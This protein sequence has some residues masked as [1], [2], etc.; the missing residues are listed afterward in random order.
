MKLS[1]V[2]GLVLTFLVVVAAATFASC[3]TEE[4]PNVPSG[5][6]SENCDGGVLPDGSQLV[7][8]LPDFELTILSGGGCLRHYTWDGATRSVYLERRRK[9]WGRKTGLYWPG[10]G[11]HWR[12][13]GKVSRGVLNESFVEFE[14]VE[15]ALN[16]LRAGGS[17]DPSYGPFLPNVPVRPQGTSYVYRDDGLAV[18]IALRPSRR[19]LNVNVWQILIDGEKPSSLPGSTNDAITLAAPGEPIRGG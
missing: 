15:T 1:S 19:Q 6:P 10:P 5:T 9:P 8:R 17:D 7:V 14:S 3:S 12:P 11:Y 4:R 13:H 2:S 18:G 16:W